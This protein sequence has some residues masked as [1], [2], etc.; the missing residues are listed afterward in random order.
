MTLAPSAA[1]S[2]KLAP[3]GGVVAVLLG[4]LVVLFG[5][6]RTFAIE[7]TSAARLPGVPSC[8]YVVDRAAFPSVTPAPRA[9]ELEEA[10]DRDARDAAGRILPPDADQKAHLA[11]R[12]SVHGPVA[13]QRELQGSDGKPPWLRR[14]AVALSF[15]RD[16]GAVALLCQ[17]ADEHR[18]TELLERTLE[19]AEPRGAHLA[20]GPPPRLALSTSV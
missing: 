1:R 4:L 3:S 17:D 20:R 16:P 14:G 2:L 19:S 10:R 11:P 6:E 15:T 12:S 9:L 8:R 5:A 7:A 18:I 13:R